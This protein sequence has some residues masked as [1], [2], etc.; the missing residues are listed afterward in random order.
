[1]GRGLLA[2][3][4]ALLFVVNTGAAHNPQLGRQ[5]QNQQ[6]S[7]VKKSPQPTQTLSDQEILEA[8]DL[9]DRHGY[10]VN[11]EATGNDVSLRHALIAFQ[12]IEGRE[13]TG[14][15][16]REELEA[17][18]IAQRPQALE[19]G[20]PHIEIDLHRQVLFVVDVDSATLRILPISSGSGEFFTEGGVTRQAI[21]PTGRFKVYR[22]IEGWRKSPLGLLYYPNYIYGGVAIHGGPSVPVSPAS[23]G[24]IRIPMF[25]S[26][27]FSEIATIG[28]VVVVYD[29][30]TLAKA[31]AV[32]PAPYQSEDQ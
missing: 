32:G 30:A 24:C 22:K 7:S 1:M 14:V 9:L 15:L 17:L 19:T 4:F 10:W 16:T 29:S 28:M 13:R 8:R 5:S 25:A 18:R 12:K 21:T 27:E 6:P 11:L 31:D 26:R 2:L 20:Y 23:H 3:A